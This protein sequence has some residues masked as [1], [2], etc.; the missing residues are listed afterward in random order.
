MVATDNNKEQPRS[1]HHEHDKG[2]KYLLSSKRVFLQLLRSFVKQGWVEEIDES[3]LVLINKSYILPDFS[4]KES[5]IVYKLT[6]K[7]QE[8]I[9]YI[10]TELQ[11]TV[12]FQ[13]PYRLLLYQ[14][15]I[16]RDILKNTPQEEAAKK[17]FR[18]PAIVPIVLYNGVNQWTAAQSFKE[19]CSGYQLF[20]DTLLDF[21]YILIHVN[22]Y[23]KEDL[24]EIA[25]VIST[26][27]LLDQKGDKERI[28][29]TLEQ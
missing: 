15:E 25:N 26:V 7:E 10:L 2:Y 24:M 8:V 29:Y 14:V 27:F 5:D 1:P 3:S 20:A 18:L 23:S 6:L 19:S 17:D 11:S 22:K 9:F 4:D 12:D 16:W 13:M 21:K 28:L